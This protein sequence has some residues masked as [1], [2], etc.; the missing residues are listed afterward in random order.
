ML[1]LQVLKF[2]TPKSD[3]LSSIN[4]DKETVFL[5]GTRFYPNQKETMFV[6]VLVS[7]LVVSQG[8][9]NNVIC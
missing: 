6:L 4:G 3:F 8:K 1:F 9:T 7:V 5:F 2:R